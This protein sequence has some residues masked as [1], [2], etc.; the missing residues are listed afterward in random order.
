MAYSTKDDLLLGSIPLPAYIDVDKAIQDAADEIDSYIGFTYK[1]PINM[2]EASPVV[3]PARLLI[4]R[5]SAHLSSGRII[6]SLDS[7]GQNDEL[8]QYGLYLVN[9][10]L[11]ALAEI[12]AGRALLDG[13]E[14]VPSGEGNATVP[15]ISNLDET[16]QVEDFYKLVTEPCLPFRGRSVI[17]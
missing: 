4:K 5:I 10:A 8:H 2:D 17:F 13:A 14:K 3:R 9:L 15:L 11:E 12:K 6:M 1:T 7:S 16:S